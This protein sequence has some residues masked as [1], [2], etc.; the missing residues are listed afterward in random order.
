MTNLL[1]VLADNPAVQW[2]VARVK[3]I[4]VGPPYS[5]D[6]VVGAN[7]QD[8]NTIATIYGAAVLASYVPVLND[9]VHVVVHARIGALVL[10]PARSAPPAPVVV[11]LELP[12]V[13]SFYGGNA[14]YTITSIGDPIQNLGAT[15][16]TNPD[17]TRYILARGDLHSW[18]SVGDNNVC[19]FDPSVSGAVGYIPMTDGR[20]PENQYSNQYASIV[21][22]I[23][24][25]ATATCRAQSYKLSAATA[26]TVNYLRVTIT[27]LSWRSN[28]TI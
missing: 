28:G 13:S 8:P 5:V 26:V 6:L 22:T 24:P 20:L 19:Y 11:P 15:T 9:I 1:N 4:K 18:A 21:F 14:P 7:T 25:K 17:P 12:R 23:A 27:A 3:T 16:M 2:R 10:G